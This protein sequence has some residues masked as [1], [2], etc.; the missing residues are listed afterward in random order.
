MTAPRRDLAEIWRFIGEAALAMGWSQRELSRR[1][2]VPQT[3]ISRF[4]RG[5]SDALDLEQLSQ[6]GDAFGARI[7]F[8]FDA[9]FLA[10]RARQRDQVHA[11]C[12][13]FV[14]T[15]LRRA[16][17]TVASEV[18]VDG[19]FGPG[20][21]DVLG[22][23]PGS[24]ALLVIEIKT[25][26]QDLGRVQ[27][28]LGWYLH[29]APAAARRLGWSPRRMHG[30]LLV[31]ATRAVDDR[32]RENRELVRIAFPIPAPRLRELIVTPEAVA[33]AGP[34]IALID[35]LRRAATWLR[36]A[37]LDGRNA[38]SPHRDYAE[39]ARK[40]AQRRGRSRDA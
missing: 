31:L 36:V 38:R 11:R 20:W 15:R 1:S 21:I 33:L 37:P 24:G 5:R 28:T 2:G 30:A 32:L 26:I 18:E 27:R 34:A 40:L 4:V 10:D 7:R 3:A 8:T 29:E 17:W 16:G 6:I 14:A 23:H 19:R 22:W 9:P 12:I 25:E 39:V 35:P 13:G